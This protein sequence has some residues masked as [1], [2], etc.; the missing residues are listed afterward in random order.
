MNRAEKS[1]KR[2]AERDQARASSGHTDDHLSRAIIE[3]RTPDRT[4]I[5]KT[6][7]PAKV[8]QKVPIGRVFGNFE[9]LFADTEA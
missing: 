1:K 2:R 5:K 6:I 3:D 9:H 7:Y 8:T 4:K